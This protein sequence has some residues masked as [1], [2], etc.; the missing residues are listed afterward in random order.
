MRAS[1]LA[2]ILGYS[3]LAVAQTQLLPTCA[4]ACVGTDFGGCST[5]DVRCICSNKEL[6]T[7][8]ACCVSTG[9]DA[10]DQQTVIDFAQ[11]LCRPQ[12]V[13]DLP[14]T[15]TCAS[16]SATASATGTASSG[17]TASATAT[18]SAAS[19]ASSATSSAASGVAS[20][21]ASAA[22]SPT[23]GAGMCQGNAVGM[24]FGLVLAGL[25]GAL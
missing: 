1:A 13:T 2:V 21:A 10:E 20:S 5:L 16:S 15:A 4:Q 18:G 6:L 25:L 14:T 19:S 11:N 7:G 8:L 22:A 17:T 12:G 24:G 23:A 3:S 9:C